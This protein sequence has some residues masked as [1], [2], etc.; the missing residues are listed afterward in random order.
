MTENVMLREI[1][2][3]TGHKQPGGGFPWIRV[4][5]ALFV[6]MAIFMICTGCAQTT[7]YRPNGR[8]LAVFQGDMSAVRFRLT[9]AGDLTWQAARVDHST[10]TKAQG[11]AAEGKIAA[12]GTGIAASGLTYLLAP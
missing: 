12:I 7:L 5:F 8:K 10:A 3:W 1:E 4:L 2:E 9:A 11:E 6:G